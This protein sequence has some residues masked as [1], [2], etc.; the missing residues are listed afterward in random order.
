MKESS[1]ERWIRQQ[2]VR[3]GGLFLKWVS[4]G[5]EGVP[6]RIC[7]LPDGRIIFVELKT[8]S[9]K[10]SEVQKYQIRRLRERGCRVEVIF[11][12]AGAGRFMSEIYSA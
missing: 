11:G 9:G 5:N 7:I 6:D 1:I 4:P 2:I 12:M 8:E 3:S 10:L